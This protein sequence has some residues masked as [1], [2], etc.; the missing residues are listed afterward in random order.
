MCNEV[1]GSVNP[2]T[3]TRQNLQ[4]KVPRKKQITITVLTFVILITQ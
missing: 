2:E 1:K 3:Y 4:Y